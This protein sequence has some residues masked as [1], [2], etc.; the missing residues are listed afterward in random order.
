MLSE[1]FSLG[2]YVD[3]AF[4]KYP[5]FRFRDKDKLV[6]NAGDAAKCRRQIAYKVSRTKE[7][8]PID[9]LGW[10]RLKFGSM[11]ERGLIYEV[12]Q[13]FAPMGVY[14]LS[15][16]AD[17]GEHGTF[18]GTSWHGYR[19]LD[20][21]IRGP[22]G[23]I[24]TIVVEIKTKIGYGATKVIK[25]NPWRRDYIIPQPDQEWGQSQQLSLYL[26]DAYLKTVNNPTFSTP[27]VDGILLQCLYADGLACWV[28][29]FF[30]Y[31]PE[32]DE[33]V[34]YRVHCEEIPDICSPLDIHISLEAI[35]SRW[36]ELD[37][38][39]ERGELPP[40]DFERK[41]H[42]E[43]PRILQETK[44]DIQKAT[45]NQL[46]LGDLQCKYC[47]YRDKCANDLEI[48]ASYTDEEIKKLKQIFLQMNKKD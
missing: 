18:Y 42:I 39:L 6:H 14:I 23:K 8:N 20:M 24:R 43:D 21:G 41:Y 37:G 13:K 33:A 2:K 38:Y 19:D 46:L 15:T 44:T 28:E 45:K 36:K 10:F 29:Y 30:E 1:Q 17:C 48:P 40:P 25:E 22:D 27:I 3:F 9:T 5:S 12:L 7:S 35:A 32:E 47:S 11:L 4:T 26:R 31:R 16:Q 34:C